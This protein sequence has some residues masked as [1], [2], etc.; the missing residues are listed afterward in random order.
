MMASFAFFCRDENSFEVKK[1]RRHLWH[2][3]SLKPSRI[4]QCIIN[5]INNHG[6]QF[7]WCITV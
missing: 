7:T 5:I 2:D 6:V 1:K 3:V 4:S